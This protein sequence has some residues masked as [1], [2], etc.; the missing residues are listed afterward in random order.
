ATSTIGLSFAACAIWMSVSIGLRSRIGPTVAPRRAGGG[1]LRCRR[2]ADKA[3]RSAPLVADGRAAAPERA[4]A[5]RC[6]GATPAEWSGASAAERNGGAPA[7][8]EWRQPGRAEWLE[9][10]WRDESSSGSRSAQRHPDLARLSSRIPQSTSPPL[11]RIRISLALRDESRRRFRAIR[12]VQDSARSPCCACGAWPAP[13]LRS[14]VFGSLRR[15]A[16]T[17]GRGDGGDLRAHRGDRTRVHRSS[18]PATAGNA[19][20]PLAD[21]GP[22]LAMPGGLRGRTGRRYRP[23]ARRKSSPPTMALPHRTLLLPR[24]RNATPSIEGAL[25]RAS[26]R[27]RLAPLVRALGLEPRNAPVPPD[28]RGAF[29]LAGAG[30]VRGLAVVG[31]RGGLVALVVELAGDLTAEAV[32]TTARRVRAHDPARPYLFLFAA[33]RYRRLAFASFGLDGELRHLVIERA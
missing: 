18:R 23:P 29:G 22:P 9:R 20:S 21:R 25:A 12:P 33:Q 7:E 24:V 6:R 4:G 28:A 16:G 31:E 32:A 30:Q 14:P 3:G 15:G 19:G 27:S 11:V 10:G 26:A 13:A 17:M 5:R 8:A 1:I 2:R